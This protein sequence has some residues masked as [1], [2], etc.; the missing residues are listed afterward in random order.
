MI[1][2]LEHYQQVLFT[3]TGGYTLLSLL[4]GMISE[5]RLNKVEKQLDKRID[6]QNEKITDLEK[7]LVILKTKLDY[8]EKKQINFY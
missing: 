3:I 2:L 4:F 1:F 6:Q 5:N 8:Y 7:E